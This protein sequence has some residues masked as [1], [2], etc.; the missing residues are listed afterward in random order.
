MRR[1]AQGR[2]RT[3]G[4]GRSACTS[5]PARLANSIPTDIQTYTQL[6]PFGRP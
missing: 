5:V 4:H 2:G 1:I 3:E 6:F